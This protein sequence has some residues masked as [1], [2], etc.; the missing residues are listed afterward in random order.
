MD[1]VIIA[2]LIS[3]VTSV[4][5]CLITHWSATKKASQEQ[6]KRIE[7]L[8]HKYEMAMTQMQAALQQTI[9]V[10]ECKFDTLQNDVRKHNNLVER[11]YAAE[12]SINVLD[13]RLKV[14]N[15]RISDLENDGK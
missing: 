5:I 3:S 15:N 1:S 2:T 9:A 10:L 11:M 8:G 14:A 4:T 7:D 12:K 6:D 13:E